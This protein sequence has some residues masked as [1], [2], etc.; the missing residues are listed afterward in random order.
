[1][2][3]TGSARRYARAVFEIA[4]DNDTFDRWSEDLDAV[5]AVLELPETQGFLT[6]SRVS[7]E[8]KQRLLD[9]HLSDVS[10][11]ARNL[12]AVLVRRGRA[13]LARGIDEAYRDMLDEHRGIVS[14]TVTTAVPLADDL[15]DGVESSLRDRMGGRD[16][17]LVS[18]VDENILGGMVARVGDQ[19]IDGSVRTRLRHM[20]NWLRDEATS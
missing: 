6:A 15:R 11:E 20:R 17:R 2:P 18:T 14:A 5:A 1:M 12:V 8:Q 7:D 19:V 9:E 16:L 13:H 4:R 10:R 3:S